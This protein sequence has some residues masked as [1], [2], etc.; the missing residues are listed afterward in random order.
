MP[1]FGIVLPMDEWKTLAARLES[2]GVEFV[3]APTI[4]FEG[5]PGE[6]ATMFFLDPAGNA[7]E[8]KAMADPGETVREELVRLRFAARRVEPDAD[9]PARVG[10]DGFELPARRVVTH[11][12]LR[13]MWP[14]SRKIRPPSVSTSSSSD[15]RRGSTASASSS[16]SIRASAS[17][18]PSSS[19]VSMPASASSCSS[20]MSPTISSTTSSIVTRPSVPPNSSTTMARWI[21]L[22]AHPRE[23]LDHAHRFGDEQRLAHQRV[24]RAVAR[25]ID[26]REED[27]LDV[28][29]P[30]D[31][32][33]ALAV[34][35]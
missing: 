15:E 3:I 18:T 9:D 14:A 25:R 31:R 7:L 34:D 8:F 16:S 26:A 29:H 28:D 1:H 22:G 4:R 20:S 19:M 6:Q 23:K 2:A 21:A 27:V 5:E 12:P 13:G 32:I 30:D 33:E 11:S 35:G 17:Q 24:Q 10:I